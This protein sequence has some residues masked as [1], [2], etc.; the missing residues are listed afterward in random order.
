MSYQHLS[1]CERRI[2]AS[3]HAAGDNVIQIGQL[4]HR[5]HTTINRE[6]KRNAKGD[7]Y[8]SERA[9]QQADSRRRQVRHNRRQEHEPLWQQIKEWLR[10]D[11]SPAIIQ[12]KLKE[13]Y[14]D[15]VRMRISTE[16]LYQ[17]IY[18]DAKAGGK[19]HQHL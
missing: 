14:P 12:N 1:R 11:W 18:R 5:H 2:I 19:W 3:R 6:L 9:E 4:F 8:D 15:D 7:R 10:L 16:T 13:Y 17:W